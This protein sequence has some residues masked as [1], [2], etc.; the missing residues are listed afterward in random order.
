MT[1]IILSVFI[2]FLVYLCTVYCLLLLLLLFCVCVLLPTSRINVF[3]IFCFLLTSTSQSC[4]LCCLALLL[5]TLVLFKVHFRGFV[6]GCHDASIHIVSCQNSSRHWARLWK[7]G[8]VDLPSFGEDRI[9]VRLKLIILILTKSQSKLWILL[10]SSDVFIRSV[11]KSSAA[12]ASCCWTLDFVLSTWLS[13]SQTGII[14]SFTGLSLSY[15]ALRRNNF[16]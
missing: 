1:G 14:P 9:L 8:C 5:A 13:L 15:V 10:A 2:I 3:I 7:G 11:C 12:V 6:T 16:R 4:T